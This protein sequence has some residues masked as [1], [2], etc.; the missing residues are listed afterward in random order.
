[1]ALHL[2]RRINRLFLLIVLTITGVFLYN[3]SFHSSIPKI[4]EIPSI[5]LLNS[6]I[7]NSNNNNDQ[8]FEKFDTTIRQDPQVLA[9]NLNLKF[10]FH[11]DK[12]RD[13]V[14]EDNYDELETILNLEITEPNVD[15]LVR[16]INPS[17]YQR[18]NATLMILAKNSEL[19]G[20][21]Y[22]MR[23]IEE[24]FNSNFH[25]PY[26]FL[27]DGDFNDNFKSKVEKLASGDVYFEKIEEKDWKQP[28]WIDP[29]KQKTE[30]KVLKKQ[31]IA[32]ANKVSYHNMC[33]YY[34]KGFYNHP[35]M[36]QFKY[37]WRFEPNT[38]YFCDISY[39][40]F[41]FMEMN[42]KVYGFVI[43]LYDA[44]ETMKTL[45]P[46]TLNFLNM[47]Y[48]KKFIHPNAA[49]DFLMEDMQNPDKTEF[50]SG[51]ST[52]HFWT[53][54]EIGNMDFYRGEAYN[55]WVNYLE[56]TG[57]FY[58]ERW[59]DAPV[60]SIGLSLFADKNDIHWFRDIGYKHHPYTNCPNSNR[61]QGCQ[62]GRFTYD[63]LKDQ[64][65]LSNWWNFEMDTAAR[66]LY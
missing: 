26:V 57:G 10:K 13:K 20:V 25:Y 62:P 28:D 1:M 32:Y 50:T 15:N 34:S 30:M 11:K 9:D 45:W 58:Y 19:K 54:F 6:D 63:H 5:P 37:Y 3:R 22:T 66:K 60:R 17:M 23:Q 52:C 43:S 55:T 12:P 16:P 38:D 41:K 14:V 64:N 53:N 65:C 46:Q 24:K 39:D 8:Q 27:N 29:D 31:N 4:T 35:R 33:R 21:L 49:I 36:K 40:V 2:T 47:G 42:K 44:Q 48:N 56:Q 18:E 61:C 59:G 51:Y 7:E